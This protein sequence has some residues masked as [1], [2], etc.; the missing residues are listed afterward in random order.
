MDTQG[1]TTRLVETDWPP[2]PLSAWQETLD[3][4]HMLTQIMGKVKLAL[5]PFQNEWWNV[6]LLLTA[7]GL[8]TGPIGYGQRLFQIDLDVLDHALVVRTSDGAAAVIPLRPRP[9]ADVYAELMATLR[10]LGIEVTI[11]TRPS[12]VPDPIPF[13]QDRVHDAYDPE[14]VERWWRVLAHTERVLQRFRTPFVGKSSPINFFW[15]SFDLN[16]T[17][18]SGRPATP[19][20]TWP[21][22]MQIAEQRENFSCGFWPGNITASGV[23]FGEPAFYAYIFPEPPGLPQALIR[24]DAAYYDT[25][26][27]EF[28]LRYDDARQAPDPDAAI[29]AF[30]ESSYEVAATLAEWD[31]AALEERAAVS[32]P[33]SA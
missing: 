32:P 21:R 20:S 10:S 22:F 24:P 3:T 2:L 29:L 15:G 4:V 30:F 27:G 14:A 26:L 13:D 17:R 6:A 1:D 23:A 7:R 33:A 5:T 11:S 12:E 25:T 18:F 9:V 16:H 8:T 28:V 19:P 31:R